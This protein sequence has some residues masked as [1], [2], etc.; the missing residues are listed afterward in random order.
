MIADIY[1]CP[2][3]D[4]NVYLSQDET[5][6]P[7]CAE[8]DREHMELVELG[9]DLE[10]DFALGEDAKY[11]SLGHLLRLMSFQFG[12][13][14]GLYSMDCWEYAWD[15][16]KTDLANA[17]NINAFIDNPNRF[18]SKFKEPISFEQLKNEVERLIML[19]IKEAKLPT[20]Q[21]LYSQGYYDV[22]NN[23]PDIRIFVSNDLMSVKAS[24]CYKDIGYGLNNFV[25]VEKDNLPPVSSSGYRVFACP[26]FNIFAELNRTKK[27]EVP[28]CVKNI[29]LGIANIC[30]PQPTW[31]NKFVMW[32]KNKLLKT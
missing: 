20:R 24:A 30:I 29:A 4:R 32:L 17:D 14:A 22:L 2:K 21:T 27:G 19:A 1:Y 28:K 12:D 5:Y 13:K 26:L 10:K 6:C 11:A 15:A 9:V 16:T 18:L 25:P 3:C 8:N 31:R 7:L 23:G